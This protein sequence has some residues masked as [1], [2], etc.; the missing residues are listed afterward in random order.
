VCSSDLG[1]LIQDKLD[2][3]KDGVPGLYELPF[4]GPLFGKTGKKAARTELIVILIPKV[5]A[6]DQDVES[7]SQ[8]FRNRLRG[9]ELK[10]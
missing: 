5:I 6:S 3:S 10:F 9:L 1:G 8:D 7:V 2:E 4:L